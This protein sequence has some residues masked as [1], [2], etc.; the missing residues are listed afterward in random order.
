QMLPLLEEL[1]HK[2]GINVCGE[3][4]EY[5]TITLDCPLFRKKIVLDDFEVITHSDDAIA[6]VSYLKPIKLHLEDK[7]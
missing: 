3:G 6:K 1:N 7:K 5:E 4:G 2:F